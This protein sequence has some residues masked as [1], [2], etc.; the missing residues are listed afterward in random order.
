MHDDASCLT[1]IAWRILPS[2][3][4]RDKFFEIMQAHFMNVSEGYLLENIMHK[5][6]D[7][8]NDYFIDKEHYEFDR[9]FN[10]RTHLD[11]ALSLAACTEKLRASNQ[12]PIS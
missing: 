9:A 5:D 1:L 3:H 10:T 4:A 2:S 12:G 8:K 11:Q 7:D 6:Y